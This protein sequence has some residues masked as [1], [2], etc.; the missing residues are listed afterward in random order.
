MNQKKINSPLSKDL[1][2]RTPLFA[3][4]AERQLE[5][6]QQGIARIRLAEKQVLVHRDQ[7]FVH[8][9]QVATGMVKLGRVSHTGEEKVLRLVKPGETFGTALMF[10]DKKRY[11][12]Q[13]EAVHS[14]EV[15]SIRANLFLEILRES[16][17]TCFKIMGHL[18]RQLSCHVSNIDGLCLQSAPCRLV[19]FLLASL[20][21]EPGAAPVVHL[22]IPKHLLASHISVKPET[23]SRILRDLSEQ[24]II[25][26]ERRQIRIL[27][28]TALRRQGSQCDGS[29]S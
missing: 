25:E 16:P 6:L 7:E 17:E 3:S 26:V 21:P 19:R 10:L 28:L 24:G 29:G 23:L 12:V 5:R 2:R 13:A 8:F 22:D 11:P 27:D 1:I 14:G 20:P 15:L 4:L 9:Y 18:S